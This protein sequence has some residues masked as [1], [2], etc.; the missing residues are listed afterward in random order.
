MGVLLDEAHVEHALATRGDGLVVHF[1]QRLAHA[2]DGG[3]VAADGELVILGAD[4]RAVRCEHFARRLWIDEALQTA[5]AQR[6]SE[7]RRVGKECVSTCRS[8]WSPYH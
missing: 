2:G 1:E 6:R 4:H 8:R 3:H 5:L 7:E